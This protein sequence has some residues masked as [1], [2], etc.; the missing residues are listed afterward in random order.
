[1]SHQRCETDGA[2]FHR[3]WTSNRI[4]CRFCLLS[5]ANSTSVSA[6]RHGWALQSHAQTSLL[7]PITDWQHKKGRV[8]RPIKREINTAAA[9]TRVGIL[10]LKNCVGG[11]LLETTLVLDIEYLSALIFVIYLFTFK[12]KFTIVG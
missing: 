7:P 5:P 3:S 1:M 2:V 4:R 6:L 12:K 11:F 9:I 8:F 10:K